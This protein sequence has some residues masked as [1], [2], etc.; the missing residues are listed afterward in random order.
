LRR[1]SADELDPRLREVLHADERTPLELAMNSILGHRPDLTLPLT[2]YTRSLKRGRLP[3]RLV[4]LVRLRI[5]FHN[6][7][8]SCMA[9]RYQDAIDDGLTEAIVCSLERPT[10]LL[11]LT[12]AELVAVRFADR[13]A[14]DH[15]AIDDA[16]YAD[17]A[18]HFDEGEIVELGLQVALFVGMGRFAASLQILEDLP[19]AFTAQ[20][21]GPIAPWGN[22]AVVV[23]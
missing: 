13:F 5:A 9:I 6:Q 11:G 17:L 14:T 12:D 4:E 16:L 3:R 22:D 15:L 10:D 8:R 23:R 20:G 1:L 2:E 21:T 18:E 19:R 7:C